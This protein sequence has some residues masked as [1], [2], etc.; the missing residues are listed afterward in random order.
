MH[1]SWGSVDGDFNADAIISDRQ[2]GMKAL[3][4]GAMWNFSLVAIFG[5]WYALTE[6]P[7]ALVLVVLA[8]GWLVGVGVARQVYGMHTM[9]MIAERR[10]QII[11]QKLQSVIDAAR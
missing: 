9:L 1:Q 5:A 11:E 4:F 3:T 10:T 8:V 7:L 6:T 2:S